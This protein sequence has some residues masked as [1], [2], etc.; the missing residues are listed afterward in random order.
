M[1]FFKKYKEK[2]NK[3]LLDILSSLKN[4]FDKTK[5]LIINLTMHLDD[6]EKK[7]KLIEKELEKRNLKH[8]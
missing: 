2:P 1:E 7:F 5:K 3:E 4:E 6:V 8:E